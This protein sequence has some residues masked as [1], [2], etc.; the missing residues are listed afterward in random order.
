M[1]TS[2]GGVQGIPDGDA[3]KRFLQH[4]PAMNPQALADAFCTR[5][6]HST[7]QI[8][9]KT[10]VLMEILL[11]SPELVRAHLP[12]FQ[13]NAGLLQLVDKIRTQ[14]RN[15][16]A[17]ENARRVLSLV[18]SN[19]TDAMLVAREHVAVKP[20]VRHSPTPKKKEGLSPKAKPTVEA[21]KKSNIKSLPTSPKI[22]AAALASHRRRSQ[23][24]LELSE[25]MT[26]EKSMVPPPAPAPAAKSPLART[27]SGML[28]RTGSMR[29]AFTFVDQS[30]PPQQ[31]QQQRVSITASRTLSFR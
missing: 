18:R 15:A 27:S 17:R 22:T 19:G 7:W 12:V 3:L 26:S 16:I 8:R 29:S 20:H 2:S 6:Q 11:E 24:G 14:D 9:A 13:S 10:L 28:Q 30:P 5:L 4:A 25:G 1:A 23:K 31:S 21:T